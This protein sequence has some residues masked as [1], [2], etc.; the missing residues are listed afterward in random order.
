LFF[1]G[2]N[3]LKSLDFKRNSFKGTEIFCFFSHILH[4]NCSFP[5]LP[6]L[7]SLPYIS[8][9]PQIQPHVSAQKEQTFPGTSTGH[10][11]T[12]Y[13]R[14]GTYHHI[15]VGRDNPV[16]GKVSHDDQ[17]SQRQPP[18]PLLEIPQE[19]QAIYP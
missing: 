18:L 14:L 6:S 1:T 15:K 2:A 7:K 4:S 5:F 11:I 19:R 16:G 13:V 8:L 3:N 12:N 17:K 10:S 9:L